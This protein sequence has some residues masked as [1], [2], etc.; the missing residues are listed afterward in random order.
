MTATLRVPAN[1]VKS[2]P[3]K[4]DLFYGG[5]WHKPKDE[6]SYA[7]TF[8]PATGEPIAYVAIA[9][10]EDTE[11]AIAAAKAAFPAWKATPPEKRAEILRK[12]ATIVR[13]HTHDLAMLDA[14]NAGNPVKEMVDDVIFA[15]DTMDYFAGLIPMI[16]GDTIPQREGF[17]YTI[18]EPLGVVARL[19]AY[20]H[21]ILFSAEKIAA[22]LA[23][24][25]CVIIKPA[26][27]AP[28][29]ALRLA[30][31]LQDVFPP[32]V[33][34]F[35]P[36]GLESG[37]V[38]GTH[39]DVK[40]VTLVGSVP[41]GKAILRGSADTLKPVLLE[42]GGKNALV[43][44]PDA[45]IDKLVD[46]VVRGMNFAWASQSCGS[47]SR[48]FLHESHHDEVLEKA[49][50]RIRNEYVPGDPTDYK[51]T[52]GPVI[53]KTAF[54]R[55]A[56]YV[57]GAIAEGAKL[58]L[59]GKRPDDVPEGSF[60]YEPTIFDGVTH[61]MTIAREEIFGPVLSVFTWKDEEDLW[62]IVND[63]NYGLT[64]SVFTENI[65]IA[66]KAVERFEAGYVWV[67]NVALHYLGMPFGGYKN[68]GLGRDECF[69]E[70]ISC[71]QVKSVNVRL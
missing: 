63:T 52:M 1:A 48:V 16:R 60:F 67:N 59:G 2:M 65:S 40:M 45:N 34:S 46:G 5:A 49:I 13:A 53:N 56:G 70:M 69:D 11:D 54:D 21:P 3:K 20:N 50:T 17:H 4:T 42:L 57:K 64:G 35:V 43:A 32:G 68:S 23:A 47:M 31:I 27:Q 15:A 7:P 14:A 29:S 22:P 41:T 55:T 58:I 61:D 38:L 8:N 66:Q 51:T 19:V 28:L 37:K 18:R 9:S 71:T 24:G 12:A 6:G 62:R 39:P 44:Y 10:K 30:E 25:N 26:E 33:L 36:G